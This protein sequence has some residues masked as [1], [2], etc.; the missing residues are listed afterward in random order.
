MRVAQLIWSQQMQSVV[1]AVFG[2]GTVI[3]SGAALVQY[4]YHDAKES[5]ATRDGAAMT[6]DVVHAGGE[7]N[8]ADACHP[9]KFRVYFPK[10]STELNDD[11]KVLL[12]R[13]VENVADCADVRIFIGAP[14]QQLKS[15]TQRVEASE[16]SATLL[17]ALQ[18]SGLAGDVFVARETE[19]INGPGVYIDPTAKNTPDYI[20]VAIE[21]AATARIESRA[22]PEYRT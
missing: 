10:G 17:A 1:I 11:G 18:T 19:V 12:S 21:P 5:R 4:A 16:R 7:K 2:I 8:N 13:A 9:V 22:L 3:G 20:A 6:G 14:D 15:E